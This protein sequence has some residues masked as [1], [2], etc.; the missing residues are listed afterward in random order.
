MTINLSSLNIEQ[1]VDIKGIVGSNADFKPLNFYYSGYS[2]SARYYSGTMTI[3]ASSP[4]AN[5]PFYLIIEYT[6][7]T[8]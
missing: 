3:F 2:L 5:L 8:D 7:T 6:K 4:Y 1:L